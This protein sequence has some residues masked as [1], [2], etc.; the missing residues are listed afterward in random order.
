[1]KI[2]FDTNFLMDSV[3]F[4]IDIFSELSGNELFTLDKVI[5][6]LKEISKGKSRDAL[7]ARLSLDLTKRKGLKIL[8][9]KERT[10]DS[11]LLIYGKEGYAIATQDK[12]LKDEIKRLGG[13]V[14]YIR[15]KKY[16][17]F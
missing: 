10:A 12:V 9:S 2:I 8:K 3:K 17:V 16:V 15:Q 6:E 1:M 14:I 7:I 4:K 11:S 13:K 5:T